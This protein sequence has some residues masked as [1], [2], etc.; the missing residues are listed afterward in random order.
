MADLDCHFQFVGELLQLHA[1]QPHAV[2]VAAS[3]IGGNQQSSSAR[4]GLL[5]HLK[6]PA[7]DALHRKLCRVVVDADIDPAAVG[8]Q[9]IDTVGGHLAQLGVDKVMNPDFFRHALGLPLL[10]GVFEIPNQFLLLGVH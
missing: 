3:T 7:T 5:T 4:I 2:A 10:A 9:V 6:P 8:A 1:P